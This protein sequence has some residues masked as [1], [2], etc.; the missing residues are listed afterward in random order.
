MCKYWSV[1]NVHTCP[2]WFLTLLLGWKFATQSLLTHTH[3]ESSGPAYELPWLIYFYSE[4]KINRFNCGAYV[5]ISTCIFILSYDCVN[6][7][8]LYTGRICF[9]RWDQINQTSNFRRLWRA[10]IAVLKYP[11]HVLN[12]FNMSIQTLRHWER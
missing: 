3:R 11:M 9:N 10:Q 7:C 6:V 4:R 5:C 8:C 2:I 12:M 1:H